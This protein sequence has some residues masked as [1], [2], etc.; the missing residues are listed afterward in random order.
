MR[1][2]GSVRFALSIALLRLAMRL[3]R[4]PERYLLAAHLQDFTDQA[5]VLQ[6]Y[7]SAGVI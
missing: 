7:R 1:Y 4:K 3:T 6:R 2:F 5:T